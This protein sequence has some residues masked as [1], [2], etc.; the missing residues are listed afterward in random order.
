MIRFEKFEKPDYERLISWI[1]SEKTIIQFSVE[2]F[3]SP[4]T[5]ETFY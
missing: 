1:D 5:K 4:I 3:T 2:E